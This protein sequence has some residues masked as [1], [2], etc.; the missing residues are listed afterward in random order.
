MKKRFTFL[1]AAIMLLTM[2]VPTGE[3]W[4]QTKSNITLTASSGFG[5]SYGTN[6]TFTAGGIGFK[7]SGVMYNAKGTPN[8]FAVKQVI[9][10]RKSSNGAGVLYNTSEIS[11]I[12]SIEV[13]LVNN[14]NGFYVY[15]G[16]A[17]N[18]T[19]N[20]IA[21]SSL[22]PVTGTFSYTNT[23]SS[24]S[25]ATSYTFTFD[26]SSYSAT[27]F[28]ILNGSSANYVGSI[29]IN[30]STGYSVTYTPGS[31]NTAT[32]VVDNNISGSYTVRANNGQNGNPNFS[33]TGHTFRCWNNGTNDVNAG[34]NITVSGNV[35]L[36]AQWNPIEYTITYKP[37]FETSQPD[38][39][40]TKYYGED[41]EIADNV[42]DAPSDAHSFAGWK[43]GSNNE[44]TPGDIYDGNDALTLT[45]QW[46][47]ATMYTVSYDC[48]GGSGCPSNT[49]VE[50][51]TQ[52]NLPAAPTYAD[53][54][55][56]GWM[57]DADLETYAVNASYT[58]T[59]NVGFEAQWI[60]NLS[61]PTFTVTGVGNGT[62]N[63][64]YATANVTIQA[65]DGATIYYTTDG[66][67]PTTSSSV[68]NGAITVNT[69]GTKTIKAFAT[70]AGNGPSAI[71]SQTVIIV[72]REDATFTN[73]IYSEPFN[74][75]SS[76]DNW[77][78][79]SVSGDATWVYSSY[80]AYI[81][82]GNNSNEDWLV[83]PKMAV[84]NG[85]LSIAFSCVG[86]YGGDSD[87]ITVIYSTDY[88]GY[89]NPTEYTW[90]SVTTSPALPYYADSWTFQDIT[91]TLTGNFDHV[92]FAFKYISKTTY[93]S[94]AV[95]EMKPFSA[96]QYYHV[97]YVANGGGGTMIDP[98]LY[99]VGSEVTAL[100][101]T[102]TAPSNKVFSNWKVEVD[103]EDPEYVNGGET[104]TMGAVVTL[105]AQWVEPAQI[106]TVT[107][108]ENGATH[109]DN[110]TEGDEVTLVEPTYAAPANMTF[111]GWAEN[112]IT[113][114]S[115][116]A[117]AY[118]TE[119][120]AVASKTFY[121][122]YEYNCPT[123]GITKGWK[124]VTDATT[125]G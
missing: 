64:Y 53:H 12:T 89:G 116:S 7:D 1:I 96:K 44:W 125:F 87:M 55:F 46:T 34:D 49:I 86:R 90:N 54:T 6:H 39:E 4:G 122:V 27:Y 95:F 103:D 118:V 77:Y 13:T 91:C 102:F 5:S 80:G 2:I 16:T 105:T 88:P 97:T 94:R 58:V 98:N 3:V 25:S 108:S 43:D 59:G 57:C 41:Y 33:K 36:T 83:S 47:T 69:E 11:T 111:V 40:D 42:F 120:E 106:I 81:K 23:N 104:F 35:T 72:N 119:Y 29:V 70:K 26:L 66:N 92:Y 68:Y 21:S 121:A 124:K 114:F 84:A 113:K 19:T 99:A 62:A 107:Y 123:G 101:C 61:A 31:G 85:Q 115:E 28:R 65:A 30:Y 48:N 14:N 51:G 32:N 82:G 50:S 76:F 52:I 20:S 110:V 93:D 117:P 24:T 15:Y 17:E 18:P 63:T 45:A 75:Q 8:G 22:T 78:A 79:Y 10:F 73:G 37:G 56:N 71:A 67:D 100:E 109:S 112:P 74:S 38:I 9:Q 60:D